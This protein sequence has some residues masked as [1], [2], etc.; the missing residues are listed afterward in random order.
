[1]QGGVCRK[2]PGLATPP[3]R[4]ASPRKSQ[5]RDL[6]RDLSANPVRQKVCVERISFPAGQ[7]VPPQSVGR[8][9]WDPRQRLI[10]LPPHLEIIRHGDFRAGCG[11]QQFCLTTVSA[12]NLLHFPC[13]TV[14]RPSNQCTLTVLVRFPANVVRLCKRD[15]RNR[16]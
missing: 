16:D 7:A 13:L 1:M 15:S 3:L 10:H 14:V 8:K 4:V 5:G 12:N 2:S 9:N 11:K 6:P